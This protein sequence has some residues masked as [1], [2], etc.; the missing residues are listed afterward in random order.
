[1]IVL[2][3]LIFLGLPLTSTAQKASPP[4]APDLLI[5]AYKLGPIVRIDISSSGAFAQLEGQSYV[6][7]VNPP[8]YEWQAKA[9][10]K[11]RNTG[12]KSIK[13]VDCELLS[14]INVGT[15][16]MIRSLHMHF[17]RTIA[18]GDTIKVSRKI[19]GDELKTWSQ[20]RKQGLLQVRAS[21]RRIEYADGSVWE[22]AH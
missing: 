9:E 21:I 1:M 6:S 22:E 18:P 20:R 8:R 19:R 2:C 13:S 3:L 14:T 4:V 12:T 5:V 15:A 17:K 10:I 7:E 11:L 16:I